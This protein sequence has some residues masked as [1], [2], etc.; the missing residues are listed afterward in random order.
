[1]NKI[2][3]EGL[4]KCPLCKGDLYAYSL[5]GISTESCYCPKCNIVRTSMMSMSFLC[6][7]C[8]SRSFYEKD[9]KRYCW[10]CGNDKIIGIKYEQAK[11][12]GLFETEGFKLS[13]EWVDKENNCKHEHSNNI[14]HN[15]TIFKFTCN[16]CG[17]TEY[18]MIPIWMQEEC[19][20]KDMII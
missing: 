17:H 4:T 11:E 5:I 13:G 8:Y 16:D 1:M 3:R 7:K 18:V 20:I 14:R 2:D 12:K 10:F 19:N 9:R 15:E 6:D